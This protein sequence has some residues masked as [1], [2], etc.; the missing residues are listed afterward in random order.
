MN[1]KIFPFKVILIVICAFIFSFNGA[2]NAYSKDAE[3]TTVTSVGVSPPTNV[4]SLLPVVNND[5]NANAQI[6]TLMFRPLIW[7]DTNLKI[8]W[9]ESIAK[10]ISVTADH[11][12]FTIHLRHW[13]WS[14]GKTV[15]A[16]DALACLELIRK[17]GQRYPNTGMGG[18]PSIIKN[19]QVLNPMTLQIILKKPVNPTWFELNGLSQIFPIPAWRWKHYTIAELSKAQDKPSMVSVVD[20]PYKLKRFIIGRSISFERNLQYSGKLAT[21]KYLRFKMYSSNAS[22]FWALK[23][24]AIQADMVPHYLFPARQ[25]VR[26]LKTCISNGGYGFNFVGLNYTNP[27]VTFLRNI[28]VRQALELAVN[29]LQ[30]IKIVYHGL[31]V[32]SFCPVPTNPDTYLSPEMKKFV[33]HPALVYNPFKAKQLLK[34]AGWVLGPRGIRIHDGQRLQFTMLVPDSSQTLIDLALL[35]KDEWHQVGVDLRLHILPFNLEMSELHAHGK[36]QSFMSFWTYNPDFYPSGDG[37]FNGD[38]SF[39]NRGN[40]RNFKMTKL[41]NDVEDK[42]SIKYLY[43]YENYA[44][45]QQPVIFLP[46]PEYLVKYSKYLSHNQLMEGVYSTACT[47]HG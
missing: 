18:I 2:V 43:R 21:L 26:K 38:M 27:K 13:Q 1:K 16:T 36:W 6:I 42:V 12:Q 4:N 32:P 8:N 34:D 40:Y 39:I 31:A 35:L 7:I 46:Y 29:Q 17:Y 15:T 33:G 3:M 20:G 44:F 19:A 5:S 11:R 14:D 37:L 47:P 45:K 25:M 24:G 23:T 22:A 28:K 30:I 41:I 10:S 9:Q